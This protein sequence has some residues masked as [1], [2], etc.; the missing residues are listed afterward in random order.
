MGESLSVTKV[1]LTVAS[2]GGAEL[3]SASA[4]FGECKFGFSLFSSCGGRSEGK[5]LR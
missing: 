3:A 1:S 4:P 5:S 2:A